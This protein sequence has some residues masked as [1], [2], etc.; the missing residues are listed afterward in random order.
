MFLVH[1]LLLSILLAIAWPFLVKNSPADSK[2]CSPAEVE[3][4]QDCDTAL[5]DAEST[6]SAERKKYN[7]AWL[8]RLIRTKEVKPLETIRQVF[9]SWNILASA[10]GYLVVNG[11]ANTFTSWIPM[12]LITVK[13]FTTIK[14]GFVASAPFVGA[15][16]GNM[17]GGVISDRILNN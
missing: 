6:I 5:I 7:L 2:F 12:Y 14:M 11:I 9:T 13:G 10:F 1:F 3:Y 17:L 4:I 15:V 16:L 8:D